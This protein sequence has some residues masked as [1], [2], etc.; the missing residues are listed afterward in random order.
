MQ[1]SF[2][3][4]STSENRSRTIIQQLLPLLQ[5]LSQDYIEPPESLSPPDL[6][7]PDSDFFPLSI[8]F[9]QEREQIYL[10]IEKRRETRSHAQSIYSIAKLLQGS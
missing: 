10:L 8:L 9:G 2:S 3:C 5:H 1:F 4:T 7:I 6:A